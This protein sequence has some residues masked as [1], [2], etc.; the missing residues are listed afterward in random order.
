MNIE[1]YSFEVKKDS[2]VFEQLDIFDF[3]FLSSNSK[4][5]ESK[6]NFHGYVQGTTKIKGVLEKVLVRAYAGTTGEM[7]GEA[8]SNEAGEFTVGSLNP[9]VPVYLVAIDLDKQTKS[10]VFDQILPVNPQQ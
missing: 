9:D 8:Y 4:K 10:E 3:S 7:V 2:L 6:T 5:T 1:E